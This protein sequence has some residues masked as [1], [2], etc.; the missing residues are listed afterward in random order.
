MDYPGKINV[1]KTK[2]LVGQARGALAQLQGS[3][4]HTQQ[5]IDHSIQQMEDIKELLSR[6]GQI[7]DLMRGR[8]QLRSGT[9]GHVND[10]AK[11]RDVSRS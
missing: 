2:R 5:L 3:L 4:F 9:G 6:V 10:P 8:E 11:H 7:P 1:A